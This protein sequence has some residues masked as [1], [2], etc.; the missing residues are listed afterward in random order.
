MI[1]KLKSF[2]PIMHG[3]QHLTWQSDYG[4]Q[5]KFKIRFDDGTEGDC[6][7]PKQQPSWKIGEEYEF[8]IKES[9]DYKNIKGLK[10]TSYQGGGKSSKDDPLKQQLIIAQCSIKLSVDI[11]K[12][13]LYK[14]DGGMIYEL[15]D[16]E[17]LTDRVMSII[18]TLAK[19][20]N[21]SK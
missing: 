18:N 17:G 7:S 9:G 14:K 5:Y 10:S 1:A 8:E 12:S 6:Q 3:G 13:E 4:T 15:K 21:G 16:L 11:I 19:K 20:H 2:E